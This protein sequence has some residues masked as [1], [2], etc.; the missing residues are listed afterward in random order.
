M[1]EELSQ[2]DVFQND[3]DPLD[4][5]RELRKEEG[6]AEEDLIP[7]ETS[8][9]PAPK[10]EEADDLDAFATEKTEPNPT[11]V[12]NLPVTETS[13]DGFPQEEEGEESE[14]GEA[15]NTAAT[16]KIHKF[17][18]DGQDFEFTEKEI[19]TQ[20]STVF[21][22]AMNY[23]KKMQDIAPYRKMI[24]AMEEEGITQDNLNLAID[25]L[26]GNKDALQQI[27]ET[28]SIDAYDLGTTEENEIYEPTQYGKNDAQLALSEVTD[29][30]SRDKEYN[31]T[32]DVIDNQW[33]QN[34]RETFAGN[35]KL[36]TG[37]HN[38]IKSGLYDEVAP[39]ARKMQVLDGNT[40]SSIEYYVLAG[41]QLR[42]QREGHQQNAQ[43]N[44]DTLNQQSQD[45]VDNAEQASSEAQHRRS[46]SSPRKRADRKGVVDYLDD[47]DEAYDAWY[48][49]LQES[50]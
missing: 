4:G 27:M 32:V 6:V 15:S 31:V 43:A 40:K 28:N 2:E 5:I 7:L 45:T 22:Q 50:T 12:D 34:S 13:D 26:K 1:S 33:D 36:I 24:S 3:V 14:E 21:G 20:F 35:P 49:K 11:P 19:M 46:A 18:A 39:I 25:A 9:D 8:S 29:V 23:T 17:K 30:I 37:L 41:E 48:K 10:E 38:D 16:P 44:V 42:T 47:D